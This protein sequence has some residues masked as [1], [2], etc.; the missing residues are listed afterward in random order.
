VQY[1]ATSDNGPPYWNPISDAAVAAGETP[2]DSDFGYMVLEFNAG[3]TPTWTATE[4]RA[5]N[6]VRDVCTVQTSGQIS[7][8]SW[9]VIPADD[10]GVY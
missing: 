1:F 4:Y 8:A 3:G 9:G 5:D 10:A 6:T 7:C 2:T